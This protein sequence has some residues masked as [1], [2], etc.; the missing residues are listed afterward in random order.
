MVMP[1]ADTRC[2]IPTPPIRRVTIATIVVLMMIGCG[3]PVESPADSETNST[4]SKSR[5]ET[6][7]SPNAPAAATPFDRFQSTGSPEVSYRVTR[8]QGSKTGY[9]RVTIEPGRLPASETVSSD[10]RADAN[11]FVRDVVV[12]TI[13]DKT[14]VQRFGQVTEQTYEIKSLL[15]VDGALIAFEAQLDAGPSLAVTRG[16]VQGDRLRLV[17]EVNGE[18]QIERKDW[19]PSWGGVGSEEWSL[20]RDPLKAGETRTLNVLGPVLHEKM[21][22]KWTAGEWKDEVTLPDGRVMRLLKIDW[23]STAPALTLEGTQWMDETGAVQWSTLPSI[24]QMTYRTDRPTALLREA[25]L[26]DLGVGAMVTVKQPLPNPRQTR[27][28]TYRATLEHTNP[29]DAFASGV[30]QQVRSVDERTAEITVIAVSPDEPTEP[31][32][33]ADAP[34]SDS[35]RQPNSLIQSNDP[36]VAALAAEAPDGEAWEVARNLERL[37]NSRMKEADFSQAFASAADVARQLE[38]DCTEHAVL[39][40]ALCRAKGI[41]ARV[42][43][44]LIYLPSKSG[45]AFHMWNEVWIE[46]RWVPLDATLGDGG[47]GAERLKV[48]SSNLEGASPFVAF[49]PVLPLLNQLKLEIVAVE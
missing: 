16:E 44:G 49:L 12:L 5:S 23:T 48:T 8:L 31:I 17:T 42:V 47:V 27:R 2:D 22:M 28:V 34:P 3:G 11:E 41:P 24:G 25:K 30:S 13:F 15:D 9:S 19:D 14:R 35:A 7:V 39:L 6:Y 32:S 38:G 20:R 1:L 10:N 4:E 18:M 21:E 37:V 33:D 36:A 40:A 43:I 46:D 26:A 45:F 29:A